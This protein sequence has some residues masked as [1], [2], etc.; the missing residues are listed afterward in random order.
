[1]LLKDFD[2]VPGV[3]EV[4]R[5]VNLLAKVDHVYSHSALLHRAPQYGGVLGGKKSLQVCFNVTVDV[6]NDIY[7]CG[8]HKRQYM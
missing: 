8:T 3:M 4:V 6:C 5:E 2:L 7:I 1:M